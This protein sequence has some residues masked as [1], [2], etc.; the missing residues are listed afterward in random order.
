MADVVIFDSRVCAECPRR[1][2]PSRSDQR[3][4]SAK[5]RTRQ[6]GRQQYRNTDQ[7]ARQVS[8]L[9]ADLMKHYGLTVE[10]FEQLL[11]SQGGVCA[12]CGGP[13]RS[14]GRR[15]LDVDHDHETEVIRGLLC[16]GCNAGIAMFRHN[17]DLLIKAANYLVQA[18]SVPER[19]TKRA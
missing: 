1:F 15:R 12:I 3:F 14:K 5:C 13:Q 6:W 17:I 7:T 18:K 16:S 19:S 2:E 4:C 8:N 11:K 9:R 10:E